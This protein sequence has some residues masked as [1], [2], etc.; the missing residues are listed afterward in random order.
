MRPAVND[1]KYDTRCTSQAGWRWLSGV[2]AHK[3]AGPAPPFSSVGFAR[4]IE[5]KDRGRGNGRWAR[6]TG[7]PAADSEAR[8]DRREPLPQTPAT[9]YPATAAS[10]LPTPRS[11]SMEPSPMPLPSHAA[12]RR[13]SAPPHHRPPN[14]ECRHLPRRRRR[15]LDSPQHPQHR[16]GSA[17]PRVQRPGTAPGDPEEDARGRCGRCSGWENSTMSRSAGRSGGARLWRDRG[18]RRRI[19]RH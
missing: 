7:Q 8:A 16:L 3:S 4:A 1:F 2:T 10:A 14:E 9:T 11:P 18:L 15:L 19:R 17:C 5:S 6:E 13:P 12:R